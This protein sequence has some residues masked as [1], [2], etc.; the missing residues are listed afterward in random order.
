MKGQH[1]CIGLSIALRR[2]GE[3]QR[4]IYSNEPICIIVRNTEALIK[5]LSGL[6]TAKSLSLT[7]ALLLN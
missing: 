6:F 5:D 4:V 2:K 7:P 3:A 1:C